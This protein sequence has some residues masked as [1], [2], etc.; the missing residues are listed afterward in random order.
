MALAFKTIT[1][2]V[3]DHLRAHLLQGRWQGRLPGREQLAA[4]LGVNRKTVEAALRLL[5]KEGTL[6]NPGKGRRRQIEI[7]AAQPPGQLRVAILL[8]ERRDQ[9]SG[10]IPSILHQLQRAGHSAFYAEKSLVDL[11]M[12]PAR[13]AA[14]VSHAPADAWVVTAGS[15]EVLEWFASQ[16]RPAFALFGLMLN[17]RLPGVAPRKTPALVEATRAL[18]QLGHRRIALLVRPRRRHPQPGMAEQAFFAELR[19]AGVH[20]TSYHLPEWEET[21]ASFHSMLEAMFRVTP[22]TALIVDE[23]P[24]F[25]AVMQFCLARRLRVP[26]DVSLICTDDDP[27]FAWCRKT[28]AHIAWDH[29]PVVRRVVRWAGNVRLGN[30]DVR[31]TF[32]A[33]RFVPGG[34]I[35]AAP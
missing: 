29:R 27:A 13:V 30:A 6:R 8:S 32:T 18:L 22:P 16:S 28:V 5:E 24:F 31:Q 21:I 25:V 33:A 10:V 7:R 23:A 20:P 9:S 3:A 34:T 11:A 2:Q 17:V 15:R 14:L 26:E 4:E 19:A 12:N 1:A 35:G